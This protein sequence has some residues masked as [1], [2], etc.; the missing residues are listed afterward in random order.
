M[1]AHLHIPT[2]NLLK[3]VGFLCSKIVAVFRLSCIPFFVGCTWPQA[4]GFEPRTDQKDFVL[5]FALCNSFFFM[6]H[7]RP[8]FR[9]F[10]SFQTKITWNKCENVHPVYSAGIQTHDLRNMYLLPKS[11]EQGSRPI[12]TLSLSSH[13]LPR[14]TCFLFLLNIFQFTNAYGR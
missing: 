9:L 12:V 8:L 1:S 4:F 3:Q 2:Q 7:P 13:N 6:A 10:S 14:S 11:L 5:R